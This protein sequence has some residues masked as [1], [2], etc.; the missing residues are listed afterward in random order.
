MED[1]PTGALGGDGVKYKTY[2]LEMECRNC[3]QIENRQFPWAQQLTS[4]LMPC[5]FCG[6]D[7]LG[8]TGNRIALPLTTPTYFG[9]GGSGGTTGGTN[10]AS[11]V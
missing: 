11:S 3:G 5:N 1:K 8:F 7:S 4:T 2:T 9:S 10:G 6:C